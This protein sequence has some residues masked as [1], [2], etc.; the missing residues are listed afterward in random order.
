MAV[1]VS[2]R[3]GVLRFAELRRGEMVR[4]YLARGE[5]EP[6][7]RLY[8]FAT[9]GFTFDPSLSPPLRPGSRLPRVTAIPCQLP[10]Q[11][12]AK[13]P[14]HVRTRAIAHVVKAIAKA[15]KATGVL[16]MM[17]GWFSSAENAPPDHHYGWIE[18][19]QEGEGLLMRLEHQALAHPMAWGAIIHRDPLRLDPWKGGEQL[20]PDEGSRLSQFI[21][22]SS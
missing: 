1:D 2:T 6:N 7:P 14:V 9:H 16:L 4:Q 17:D 18:E 10:Q 15:S 20:G 11:V 19:N 13:I 22:W 8:V 5:F 12:K 21:D 3:T